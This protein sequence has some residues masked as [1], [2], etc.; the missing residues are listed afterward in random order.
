[1]RFQKLGPDV[2]L[3]FFSSECI[4]FKLNKVYFVYLEII[5]NLQESCKNETQNHLDSVQ[6]DTSIAHITSLNHLSVGCRL[7]GPVCM[8]ISLCSSLEEG[9]ASI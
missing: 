9:H 6:P 8:N 7:Q 3:S 5:S 1:M 4:F 2:F